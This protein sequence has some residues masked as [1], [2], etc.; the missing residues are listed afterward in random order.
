M[1]IHTYAQNDTFMCI[2]EQD[3]VESQGFV[4]SGLQHRQDSVIH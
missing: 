1:Y 3:E 4:Y 2:E